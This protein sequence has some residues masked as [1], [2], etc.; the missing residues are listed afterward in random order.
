M[1]HTPT[2]WEVIETFD[3]D[4]QIYPKGNVEA[5]HN[6]IAVIPATG[7]GDD[8]ANANH[9]V[10]CV[11]LHDELVAALKKIAKDRNGPAI[12]EKTLEEQSKSW[13][14]QYD[15]VTRIAEEVLNK[16]NH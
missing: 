13:Q 2:P 5:G 9:I 8:K 10:H 11:N 6:Q 12:H 15:Y 1:E 16:C 4:F 14:K 3:Y 7:D